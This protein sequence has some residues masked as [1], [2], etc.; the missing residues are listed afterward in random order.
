MKQCPA[1]SRTYD[2]SQSFCL[3]DG[4]SLIVESEEKTEEKTIVMQRSPVPKKNK[5]LLWLGVGGLIILVVSGGIVG[6][7]VYQYSNQKDNVRGDRQTSANVSPSTASA[8][9]QTVTPTPTSGSSSPI[10]VPSPKVEGSKSTPTIKD[11]EDVTP[12]DWGTM[13]ADFKGE[14]GKTFKFRCPEKGSANAIYGSDVYADYSSICTAAVH[15]G[16]F[17]LEKGGIVT[18]EYRSG[19]SIYGSTVRNGVKSNTAS[20]HSRSFIVR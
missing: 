15:V 12:I 7:L 6:L 2:D 10:E 19:R 11:T 5:F 17:T 8:S 14:E 3:M 16:L 18:I 9:T 20:E 13:A 1:C 4:T